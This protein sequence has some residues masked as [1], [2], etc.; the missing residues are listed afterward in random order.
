MQGVV[1][2]K[3]SIFRP[4]PALESFSSE[5]HIFAIQKEILVHPRIFINICFEYHPLT[6]PRSD[7]I[8]AHDLHIK[9]FLCL[10]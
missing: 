7:F 8:F 9:G 6:K 2:G 1:A 3:V 5:L 4:N 10:K